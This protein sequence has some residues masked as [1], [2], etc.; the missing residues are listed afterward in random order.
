M[1]L[2]AAGYETIFQCEWDAHCTRVLNKHW[3]NVPKWGDVSTLTGAY[4]LDKAG[5]PDV[6]AWGSPCQDLSVAGKRAGLAG[7]KSGLF[8]DGI[9]IIKEIRELTNNEYPRFSIWENVPGALSSNGG[10]DFG[11]VL[12]EMAQAGAL[13]LE[14]AVLDAQYFGVAQRRRR[15]F[16]VAV[17]DPAD[18]SRSRGKVLPVAEGVPRNSK[19]RGK[20]GQSAAPATNGGADTS[21]VQS[22]AVAFQPGTM[23]RAVGGHW[24]EQAP[25]LRAESKS[26]DNSP[27]VAQPFVKSRHAKDSEDYETW[28]DGDVSPTLNT[29]ENHTDTRATVAIVSQETVKDVSNTITANIYHHGTVVNQDVNDGHM[30]IVSQ[31]PVNEVAAT[32][33]AT[34][35]KLVANSIAEEGNLLPVTVIDRAAFNQGPNA[36]FDTVIREDTAIPALVARGPHAVGQQVSEIVFENSYR[37]GVRIANDNVS[38]TLSAKM[39]TGGNNTP[40]VVQGEQ[41]VIGFEPGAVSRLASDHYWEEISPTLRAEMGDN[42]AAVVVP[43]QNIVFNDDR[44][45]GPQL[46]DD[47]INTLQAFMGTGGNNT[48]MVAQDVSQQG[49]VAIPIQDGREMEKHQN[50]LG[51]GENSDPSYTLDQTGAQSIAYSIREDATVGNFSATPIDVANAV[52]ALQP[53]PQSHHAQTFVTQQ[54]GEPLY[55]FDTQ[56]GSNAAVFEDQSPTLKATQAP[57]SVA[58]QYDGYNQKLEEGDGVYRSLRVGRDPSDFVMQNT[59]MV[60]R[61]LTPLECERLMGWPD[62]HTKHDADG[63]VIPDT[64]RY[65]MCGNGVASPVARWVGQKLRDVYLGQQP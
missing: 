39:G 35:S 54:A 56:F 19:A 27:H 8:H 15:I 53:S 25:T 59:S 48:P 9:R 29:F 51:V 10:A 61:R 64:Q 57:S 5:P 63:K 3:P 21:G 60:I 16:L 65:K 6:V 38:Q 46:F 18:A 32:I 30:V 49:I 62:D 31:D 45:V 40:M 41:A 43:A 26:G 24:D 42:Q 50:G 1:G 44:R 52:T 47:K 14:W 28:V 13:E 2:E 58:Y 20:K 11:V 17:F 33:T 36:Q 55:S 23:I 12:D 4:V 37:D 7:A 22:G 34:Y